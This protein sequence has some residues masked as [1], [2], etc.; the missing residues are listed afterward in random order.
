MLLLIALARFYLN[1]RTNPK[2]RV[3]SEQVLTLIILLFHTLLMA[4]KTFQNKC[5]KLRNVRY[6]INRLMLIYQAHNR[7]LNKA[8]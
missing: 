3:N 4:T 6:F 7:L 2:V 1:S 8:M 5:Y